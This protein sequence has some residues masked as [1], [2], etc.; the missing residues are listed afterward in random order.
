LLAKFSYRFLLV[1]LLFLITLPLSFAFSFELKPKEVIPGDVF[2]IAVH[3]NKD[4]TALPIAEFDGIKIDFYRDINARLIALVPVDIET[5]PKKYPVS[6]H[7]GDDKETKY[8][9]IKPHSFQ[10]KK[11]TLPEEK[12]I[13]RPEDLK[14]AEKETELMNNT[15]SQVTDRLWD[16]RFTAP[17]DTGISEP[18]GT[19]RIMNG[20]RTSVHRG[21]DYKGKTG[22]PV[23]AVNAGI[24]V[25]KE[26]LFF[27]G[28]TVV[29]DHGMGL[30]SV[31]MHLS[32]F[33]VEKG[34]AISKGQIIGLVG[35]S[36]RAT[37]P[38]LHFGLK[39]QGVSVNPLSL[40]KL[41]L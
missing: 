2:S 37:G 14:R 24:V 7:Y 5:K 30:F 32:E 3:A 10:T 41:E 36:G 28:N 13:L 22:T 29:L 4:I 9:T 34:D 18:F 38:H 31:Y 35:M 21:I 11:I 23:N 12:V 17:T 1:V 25:L 19:K 40:F 8:V 27:G 33:R 16:G 15:L 6:V 26:D 20:K 39:L